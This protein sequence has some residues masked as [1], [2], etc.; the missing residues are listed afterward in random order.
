[1]TEHQHINANSS[2]VEYFT[3]PPIIEAARLTMG[4]IDL[5]PASSSRANLSV[6]AAHIY[7]VEDDAMNCDWTCGRMWMNHP[8]GRFEE[9]CSPCGPE[10]PRNFDAK[11]GK[12]PHVC[13]SF[14]LYGNQI[15]VRRFVN[16]FTSE[17]VRQACS[18]TFAATSEAWF[19]PLSNYPQCY[20]F[21][22][23]N[24]LLPDGS[25]KKGVTKGSVVT[26]LGPNVDAFANAF[27]QLGKI[28]IPY[29][30]SP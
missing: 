20:L 4:G 8:F 15:W 5:D 11:G 17:R 7:T 30:Y 22:R 13:H 9:P 3:P 26:Y 12:K 18:I 16:E 28:K 27:H 6:R 19:Q 1:M 14:T 25:I 23:T 10:C 24:Y 2:D 29:H 21:P